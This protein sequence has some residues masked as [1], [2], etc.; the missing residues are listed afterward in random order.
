[1]Q[2][3]PL[4]VHLRP[5]RHHV[6]NDV[7]LHIQPTL[8][9]SSTGENLVPEPTVQVQEDHETRGAPADPGPLLSN[10]SPPR[11]GSIP[12]AAAATAGIHGR[13]DQAAAD[14]L[15]GRGAPGCRHAPRLP[16]VP[17][18]AARPFAP[19]PPGHAD[20]D[21]V[22]FIAHEPTRQCFVLVGPGIQP[23]LW[24]R[25]QSQ[26]APRPTPDQQRIHVPLLILV[27]PERTHPSTVATD[28]SPPTHTHPPPTHQL[29]CNVPNIVFEYD[30]N[31]LTTRNR[32]AT[33]DFV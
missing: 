16:R 27:H 15:P 9:I 4:S 2:S 17:D 11:L 20:A 14:L 12:V 3:V 23:Q 18:P 32:V 29:T 5:S 6:Y 13:R 7:F 19:A 28:I 24:S 30:F 26:P 31:L 10:A 33:T 21:A 22:R 25:S 8:S 1:M